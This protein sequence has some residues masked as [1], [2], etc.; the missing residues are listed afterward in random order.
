MGAELFWQSHKSAQ[1]RGCRRRWRIELAG[2]FGRYKPYQQ[3]LLPLATNGFR[4]RRQHYRDAGAID[5]RT[6]R[7][8]KPRCLALPAKRVLW[9]DRRFRDAEQSSAIADEHKQDR[10]GAV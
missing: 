3:N 5:L 10:S 1:R 9:L 6:D 8:R 2:I 7:Y 4:R